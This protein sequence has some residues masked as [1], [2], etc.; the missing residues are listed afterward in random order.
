MI[1][2]FGWLYDYHININAI[3][4]VICWVWVV[5]LPMIGYC[6]PLLYLSMPHGVGLF[7]Y[8]F[9]TER[10]KDTIALF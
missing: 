10:K 1:C 4:M 5:I 8:L 6:V 7:Y 9:K 2:L 3:I